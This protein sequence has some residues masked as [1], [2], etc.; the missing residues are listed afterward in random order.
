MRTSHRF[1]ALLAAVL[2]TAAPAAAQRANTENTVAATGGMVRPAATLADAS[3]LEGRWAGEGLGGWNEE[4]W[5]APAGGSIMGVYRHVK[6]GAVVFYEIMS[7]VETEGTLELRL[8]HFH[9]DLRGWEEKDDVVRFPLVRVDENTLWFD[10]MTLR[11][12]GPDTMQAWVAVSGGGEGLR[13]VS[14]TY[15]RVPERD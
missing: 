10:G 13:E 14:F 2:A 5:S 9:G 7:L 6:E 15:R 12:D 4:W 3:W 1:A 11:R 8:K